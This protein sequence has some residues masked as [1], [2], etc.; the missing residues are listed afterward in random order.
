[1]LLDEVLVVLAR[2][3]VEAAVGDDPAALDRVLVGMRRARRA[4]SR[5]RARET[6]S[7]P[8]SARV[9][10]A[11]SRARSSG[12][13]SARELARV[14]RAVEA[15]DPDVDRVD[16]AAADERH[17][18]VAGL[19]QREAALDRRGRVARQL[20]RAVVAEEVGGVE[21][22]DVQRVA[23]DP[24]AAVEEPPQRADRLAT[25]DAAERPPSRWH[26]AHL[27][28]D[29]ADPAD[30]RGDV[31]RL[32][33]RAAAQERLEEPRRLEDPRARRARPAPS[34]EAHG[35]R[36]LALD[37]C[38][39]VGADRAASQPLG[40]LLAGTPALGVERAEDAVDVCAS[41]MP[42]TRSAA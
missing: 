41:S 29:R 22:V 16:L 1:M 34:R 33:E 24:L 3:D 28:G 19:L 8:S 30:A 18:L 32:E 36:A 4:R 25:L 27:V 42:S 7:R 10:S 13:T 2:R 23:L 17:H 12:S 39:V 40:A 20:D 15:A 38:E 31:G 35:H 26:G 5:R 6:R 9:S 21:H 37:A 14:G 11:A